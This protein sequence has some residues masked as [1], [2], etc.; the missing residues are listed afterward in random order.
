M[1]GQP[2]LEFRTAIKAKTTQSYLRNLEQN[3]MDQ[4]HKGWTA[5][6]WTSRV[7]GSLKTSLGEWLRH[8]LY[9]ALLLL[10]ACCWLLLSAPAAALPIP[11]PAVL[12]TPDTVNYNNA[13]L[14][15]QDF[16]HSNLRGKAF[17]AAEMR[18]INLEGAD[19][20][21]AMLTK[22]VMLEANLRQA[23][24]TGALVDRVFLVRADLTDAI[25]EGATLSRTSLQD[26][27]IT[28]ADFTDAILDRYELAQLC[29]R[30]DGVNSVTGVST[31]DSLGCR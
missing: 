1:I 7:A 21:N 19:L 22:G 26:A 6:G 24:L 30:A 17:V 25:L 2:S 28:G 27:T 8:L 14:N 16:S 31:R 5:A 15:N 9:S 11:L 23:N 13:N 4:Q 3:A 20:S 18:G 29:K 10:M 12:P